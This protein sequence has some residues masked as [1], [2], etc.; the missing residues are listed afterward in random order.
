M[1]LSQRF[2]PMEIT[3]THSL[4]IAQHLSLS[5]FLF[6]PPVTRDCSLLRAFSRDEQSPRCYAVRSSLTSERGRLLA[7]KTALS[8]HTPSLGHMVQRTSLG[9]RHTS[10]IWNSIDRLAFTRTCGTAL[11]MNLHAYFQIV[12]GGATGRVLFIDVRSDY[13]SKPFSKVL[14]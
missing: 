13:R 3:S 8:L 1:S 6:L 7:S 2:L 5:R 9:R 12:M 10:W 11:K 4:K 14:K